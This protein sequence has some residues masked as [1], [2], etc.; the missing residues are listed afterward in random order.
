[1]AD[2]FAEPGNTPS[3][4]PSGQTDRQRT[5]TVTPPPPALAPRQPTLPEQVEQTRE[6][7]GALAVQAKAAAD[8]TK[9]AKVFVSTEVSPN[10]PPDAQ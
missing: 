9:L 6:A 10:R 4:L 3:R 1:M 8:S 2:K 7:F 5:E